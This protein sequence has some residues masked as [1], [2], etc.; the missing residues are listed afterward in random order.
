[1]EATGM[2]SRKALL[3]S[4]LVTVLV[5]IGLGFVVTR[6]I[7][8]GYIAVVVLAEGITITS[9]WMEVGGR[10]SL[11]IKKENHYVSILL[12]PPFDADPYA[13]GIK[14]PEG[15]IINPEVLL[16]DQNGNEYQMMFA[17][18]RR[19]ENDVFVNYRSE[20]GLPPGKV[21]KSVRLRSTEPLPVKQILW[22]GYDT[23]DLP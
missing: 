5:V 8:R 11:E 16:L 18:S 23:K 13:R 20:S 6:L 4:L 17:G 9:E 21:F 22:S 14:T 15:K 19:S 3:I 10:S 12:M 2:F 7:S 1:M